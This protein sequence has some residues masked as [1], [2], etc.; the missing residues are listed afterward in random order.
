MWSKGKELCFLYTSFFILVYILV[1]LYTSFFTKGKNL[2]PTPTL[3]ILGGYTII[4]T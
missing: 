2:I 4:Y 1:F 3:L